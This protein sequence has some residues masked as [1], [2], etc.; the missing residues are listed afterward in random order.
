MPISIGRQ[1]EVARVNHPEADRRPGGDRGRGSAG[2][3]VT[4]ISG[5]VARSRTSDQR[6]RA[7]DRFFRFGAEELEAA[8]AAQGR[9]LLVVDPFEVDDDLVRDVTEILPSCCARR[10]GRQVAAHRAARAIGE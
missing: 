4:T 3:T 6:G 5:P 9:C 8:L 10:S 7:R 2:R 1:K